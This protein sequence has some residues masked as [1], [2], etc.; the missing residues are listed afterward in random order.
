LLIFTNCY[1]YFKN[2]G[3]TF[4]ITFRVLIAEYVLPVISGVIAVLQ[5]DLLHG[6]YREQ[7]KKDGLQI[8]RLRYTLFKAT[9]TSD[10]LEIHLT[11]HIFLYLLILII[12]LACQILIFVICFRRIFKI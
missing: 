10:L 2:T 12:C 1:K 8:Y 5:V 3:H 4:K 6:T 9:I 7:K 11:V